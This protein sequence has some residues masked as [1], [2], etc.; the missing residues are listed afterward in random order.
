VILS[1]ISL[2]YD[3][4]IMAAAGHQAEAILDETIDPYKG[5]YILACRGQSACSTRKA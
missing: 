4:L 5:N 2:D 1:M 3:D